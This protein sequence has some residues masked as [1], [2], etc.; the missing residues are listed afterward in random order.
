MVNG[1]TTPQK[2]ALGT[3]SANSVDVAATRLRRY[4]VAGRWLGVRN[5]YLG[6]TVDHLEDDITNG[7]V[8]GKH[9]SEYV[10]A[11]VLV[12]VG[13]GWAYLGRAFG[14]YLSGDAAIAY[15]LSY[16]AELRAAMSFLAA[17]GIGIFNQRHIAI[18]GPAAVVRVPG[19]AGTH[20]AVWRYL[21]EM[22]SGSVS[23]NLLGSA[24]TPEGIPLSDWVQA[25]PG[26]GAWTPVARK[27][28]TAL[29]LDLKR[30]VLD[31]NTRNEASYRPTK[32]EPVRIDPVRAVELVASFW[33]LVEPS[34]V[35]PFAPLDREILRATL[36]IAFRARHGHS[37]KSAPVPFQQDVEATVAAL[38]TERRQQTLSDYLLEEGSLPRTVVNLALGDR[39][40]Q[41]S[42]EHVMARAF[43]FLRMATAVSSSMSRRAGWGAEESS[44][45]WGRIGEERG[46]WLTAPPAA[47]TLDYWADVEAAKEDLFDWMENA[48]DKRDMRQLG[49]D[50]AQA[51]LRFQQLEF[52]MVWGITS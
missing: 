38:V 31:R 7:T 17:Q 26:G 36:H 40:G 11:S 44:F 6:N 28:L 16:Y 25:M 12:H 33:D 46:L 32:F 19:K 13:D 37:H 21:D 35:H 22:A 30:F 49:D 27:L 1:L 4:L 14:S 42:H 51:L 24:I 9:L 23:A 48:E 15:H 29:G 50:C 41:A 45:W 18:T 43:I 20:A 10:A 3:A 8:N 47:E 2:A 5:R 34:E 52:A 39:Y